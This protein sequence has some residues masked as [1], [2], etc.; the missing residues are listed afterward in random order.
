MAHAILV[1]KNGEGVP[2]ISSDV[3]KSTSLEEVMDEYISEWSL[4]TSQS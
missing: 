3:Q 1:L 2:I 4:A